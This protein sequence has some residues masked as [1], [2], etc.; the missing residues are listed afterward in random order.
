MEPT[1]T[2]AFTQEFIRSVV[3]IANSLE[4][5]QPNFITYAIGP[6]SA[7]LA[8]GLTGWFTYQLQKYNTER[9]VEMEYAK[10]TREKEDKL[11]SAKLYKIEDC[12]QIVT[13]VSNLV[14]EIDNDATREIVEDVNNMKIYEL[15]PVY[16][17][18][19]LLGVYAPHLVEDAQKLLES[20]AAFVEKVAE[21]K[22]PKRRQG[23][24]MD[25]EG[26]YEFTSQ[27]KKAA[28]D[29]TEALSLTVLEEAQRVWKEA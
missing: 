10:Q 1:V 24:A 2:I 5:L 17:L 6:A 12:H 21:Y 7:V 19:L 13:D 11:I 15:K 18:Q 25:L 23:E 8:A 9:I 27:Y 22:D 29:Q 3:S 14:F 20:V 26:Y 28:L 4:S 16:R